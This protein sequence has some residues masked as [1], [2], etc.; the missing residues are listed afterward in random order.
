[1]G[2]ALALRQRRPEEAVAQQAQAA[3]LCAEMQ[4]PREQVI[5][6]LVL[7]SYLLAA[8][9]R[10]R[11]KQVYGR[12]A[13]LAAENDLK[14][15]QAQARMALGMLAGLERQ[16]AEAAAHYAASARLAEAA[17]S[18][19]LAIECWRMAGQLALEGKVELKAVE[20]WKRA[21]GLADAL[22]PDIARSTSAPEVA[23]ALAQVYRKRGLGAQAHSLERRSFELE[24]ALVAGP[25]V[26]TA[27]A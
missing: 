24:H 21:L 23:R 8:L 22:E 10:D 17:G 19:A 18:T 6:L 20:C 7:G 9:A 4:M 13:A 12:A 16:P 14:E 27:S 25:A 11:A 2:A 1:L 26:A 5:N 15:P 3:E